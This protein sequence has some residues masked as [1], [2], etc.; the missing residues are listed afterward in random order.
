MNNLINE[1]AKNIKKPENMGSYSKEDCIF[2]LKNINGLINE[3][4]NEERERYMKDGTH[5]S[6]M[7]PVED[8]PTE[9]YLNLFYKSLKKT[10]FDIANYVKNI[11]EEII[12]TRGTEIVLVSLV[13][14]GT[15]TGVLIKRYIKEVH[16]INIV[17]YGVS[18][19]R[20]KGID[21]NA[22]IYIVNKHGFD[23]LQFVD[24]WTGKGVIGNELTKSIK[25]INHK[26]NININPALAVLSDP[27]HSADI[28]GT[29]EDILIPSVY[30]NSIVSG[31]ISRTIVR[32]DLIGEKDFHGVKYYSELEPYDLSNL[33]VDEITKAYILLK[34]NFAFPRLKQ[35][36]R[37]SSGIDEVNRIKDLFDIADINKVKPGVGETTRVLLRRVPWKVIV[38]G[39]HY[40]ELEHIL[41][42]AKQKNIDIEV[43]PELKNYLCV[44]LIKEL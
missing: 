27:S 4:G 17:H 12:K 37:T 1:K 34:H 20:G 39:T 11:S 15:S 23:N 10:S 33:Y 42:L 24:G 31:L 7:L 41:L 16:A 36:I 8:V 21:E 9:E 28:Y 43:I 13:R 38:K 6:E 5:Y 14:G 30:L 3:Q 2:L 29:R 44:G 19:V 22:I 18:I 26:Y 32:E 35:T 40:P 25:V